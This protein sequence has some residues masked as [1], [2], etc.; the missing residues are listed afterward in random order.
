M[1]GVYEIKL[2]EHNL[3]VLCDMDTS[4]GGWTVGS[5][6]EKGKRSDSVL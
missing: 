1:T 2:G 3:T 6:R 5:Y 4:G